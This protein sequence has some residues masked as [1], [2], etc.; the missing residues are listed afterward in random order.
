[1]FSAVEDI[2]SGGIT[3]LSSGYFANSTW[4][5]ILNEN[6]EV[7]IWQRNFKSSTSKRLPLTGNNKVEGAKST[8]DDF[9]IVRGKNNAK[10]NAD[11]GAPSNNVGL[12][13]KTLTKVSSF[14]VR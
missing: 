13:A 1:M 4:L 14:F 8:S 2:T 3:Q 11:A 7:K 12:V 10:S 9:S 6:G 5:V